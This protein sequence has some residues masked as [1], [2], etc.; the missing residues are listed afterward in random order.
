MESANPEER[1]R[2]SPVERESSMCSRAFHWGVPSNEALLVSDN[3]LSHHVHVLIAYY[4][5]NL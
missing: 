3:Y 4:I 1:Q 2:P 5:N